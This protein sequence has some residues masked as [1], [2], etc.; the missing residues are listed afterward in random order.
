MRYPVMILVL[1]LAS[2]AG[3]C[4]TFLLANDEEIIFGRSYDFE[5]GDGMLVTNKYG[6]SKSAFMPYSD[7]AA[8]WVSRYGSLTFNQF[9]RE[10]PQGGIND[11]GLVVEL[12]WLEE[13]TYSEAD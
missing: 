8:T 12:M 9:G 11:A 13:T 1:L 7:V 4:S 5:V 6:V 10:T 2:L 3:A